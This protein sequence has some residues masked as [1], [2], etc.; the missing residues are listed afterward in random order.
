MSPQSSP[1]NSSNWTNSHHPHEIKYAYPFGH[2]VPYKQWKSQ[3]PF[4]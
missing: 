2:V 4:D 3:D 1:P